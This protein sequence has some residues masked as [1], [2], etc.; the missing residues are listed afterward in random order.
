[1]GRLGLAPPGT[2][3]SGP[4]DRPQAGG[5]GPSVPDVLDSEMRHPTAIR[6]DHAWARGPAGKA[7]RH[8]G[9][10]IDGLAGGFKAAPCRV[11][12]TALR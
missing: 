1:M 12:D 3:V 2:T 6:S 7:L 4:A 11:H 10:I 8:H 9:R 5:V